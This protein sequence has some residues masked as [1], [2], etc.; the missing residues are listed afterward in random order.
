MTSSP[1]I[2]VI[3]PTYNR[4]AT[5]ERALDH[6]EAQTV[7]P[8]ALQVIICDD[9]ST[10]DTLERIRERSVPFRIEL[11]TQANSG[12]AAARNRGLRKA[13]APYVLFINDDTMLAPDAVERH[14]RAQEVLRGE[15]LMVLGTFDLMDDFAA[16]RLGHLL[17]HTE[18]LF[19][20]CLLRPGDIADHN[21]SYTCNLSLPTEV[22]RSIG[23]D[24]VFKGPAGEDIDFGFEL[25]K[26]GWAV[27]Y[28][29]SARSHH[30]HT[31]TVRSLARTSRT[32][33]LGQAAY[34][35]KHG[36]S[37][38]MLRSLASFVEQRPQL[39]AELE[40]SIPVL[41]RTLEHVPWR[42]DSP[43]DQRVYSRFAAL[44]T[45]NFQAGIL[46]DPAMRAAVAA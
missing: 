45:V 20:Y 35:R 22:A 17:T 46:D 32:R 19:Q 9:G 3:V 24:E 4:R 41:E 27:Y 30:D 18:H 14:L 13:R 39:E 1:A 33:G 37:R 12:P 2:S 34:Y 8:D 44:F 15:K 16:T 21:F 11:V 38:A 42:D 43:L 23:F 31:M 25:G 5:L 36:V 7:G 10:D 29:P 26:H 28:E 6:L 40:R